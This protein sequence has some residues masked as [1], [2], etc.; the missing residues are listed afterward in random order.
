MEAVTTSTG[1]QIVPAGGPLDSRLV[2]HWARFIDASPLTVKA[3]TTNV[4]RFFEWLD[5]REITAPTRETV[6]EYK[7]DLQTAHKAAT[8]SSY[9]VALRIFF[10]WTETLPPPQY[11]PNIAAHVKGARI[12][13]AHKRDALTLDGQRK[14]L[15]IPDRDGLRG[16][17]NYAVIALM[18]TGGLRCMEIVNANVE[19]IAIY[20][21]SPRIFILGKDRDEKAD[22][23]EIP[24]ETLAAIRHYL[25]LR[26]R[27]EG[28]APTGSAPLFA[29]VAPRNH[30]Q[31]MTTRAVSG[32]VK[33]AL[34]E[35]G[36]DTPRLSAHSLRHSA[37]T[38]ALL[39]GEN[40]VDVSRFARHGNIST[41][42]VY[43][44]QMED[45]RNNCSESIARMLFRE[46]AGTA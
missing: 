41:T 35:A 3:Y 26:A 16:A 8:V 29:S 42:M 45:E 37:V 15:E 38:D 21:D 43:V 7:K 23:V 9:I 30:G 31:R 22:S 18:L 17:R 44:H 2:E 5:A 20:G 11:Y 46:G 36:Y 6:L 39:S 32:I 24:I 1:A 12:S 40:I 33:E 27:S 10:Q 13:K 14:I 34:R 19:D 28:R 4:R 25:K